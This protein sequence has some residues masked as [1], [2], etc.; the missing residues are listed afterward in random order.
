MGLGVSVHSNREIIERGE[1][2][3][4]DANGNGPSVFTTGPSEES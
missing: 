1:D 4:R 2:R 3:T